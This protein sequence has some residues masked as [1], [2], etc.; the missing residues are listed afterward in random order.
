MRVPAPGRFALHKLIVAQRRSGPDRTKRQKDLAQAGALLRVL[1]E[2]QPEELS[3]LWAELLDRGPKWRKL[4]NASLARL[5]PE[6]RA[7]FEASVP[8]GP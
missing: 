1:L 2:D 3:E 5:D 7:A 6:V 4:A 8:P